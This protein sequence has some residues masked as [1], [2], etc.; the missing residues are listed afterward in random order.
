MYHGSECTHAQVNG[1]AF[2]PN[3]DSG[4]ERLAQKYNELRRLLLNRLDL[5]TLTPQVSVC[6]RDAAIAVATCL[7]NVGIISKRIGAGRVSGQGGQNSARIRLPT[8][9]FSL[10]TLPYETVAHPACPPYR[11]GFKGK[12]LVGH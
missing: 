2:H 1:Q 10:P 8:L 4:D 5:R 7:S 9:V 3:Q 12:G 6:S 11:G